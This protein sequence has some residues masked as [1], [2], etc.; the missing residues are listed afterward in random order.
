MKRKLKI[1]FK[2][3]PY[4]DGDIIS[5]DCND[6]GI[7]KDLFWRRRLKDAERSNCVEWVDK[8][9]IKSKVEKPAKFKSTEKEV[10]NDNH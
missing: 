3:G 1:N 6:G 8:P 9:T 5:I 2:N 4:Y 10:E 7:P